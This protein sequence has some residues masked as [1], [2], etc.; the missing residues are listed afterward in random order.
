MKAAQVIE[1]TREWVETEGCKTPGFHGAHLMGSLA[2]MA[3]D[4]CFATYRDVDLSI[5]VPDG[6][7]YESGSET[8]DMELPYK[9]LMLQVSFHE[10]HVYSSAQAVLSNPGFASCFALG[11]ILSDPTG[12][13][14][15]LHQRAVEEFAHRK[16]V[17]AR[18]EYERTKFLESAQAIRRADSSADGGLHLLWVLVYVAGIVAVAHL[19]QPTHRRCLILMRELLEPHGRVDLC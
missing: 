13:L 4:D 1:L 2:V 14:E 19:R 18:C 7:G 6:C 11:A 5:I 15:S 3:E 17:K 12:M 16:W 10:L 8:W 9:G